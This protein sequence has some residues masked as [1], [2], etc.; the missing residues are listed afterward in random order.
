MTSGSWSKRNGSGAWASHLEVERRLRLPF[1]PVAKA[2]R[3]QFLENWCLTSFA[4]HLRTRDP[5]TSA[6]EYTFL[7]MLLMMQRFRPL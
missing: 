7:I 3:H 1:M 6:R 4:F 5:D 2:V